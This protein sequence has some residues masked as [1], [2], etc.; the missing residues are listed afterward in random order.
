MIREKYIAVFVTFL[1][2]VALSLSAQAQKLDSILLERLGD[3]L[4]LNY[5][6]DDADSAYNKALAM[7]K[8]SLSQ[9]SLQL[10]NLENKILNTT[11]AQNLLNFVSKPVVVSKQRFSI[12]EFFLF[13]PLPDQSWR[14]VPNQLDS[15][16]KN[17]MITAMYFPADAEKVFY[18]AEDASHARNIYMTEFQDS[19][20]SAPALINEH[21]T[22][23]ANE[24][25]PMLSPDGKSLFFASSGLYGVGAY[26][27]YVSKWNE[28]AKDWGTP[29]NMGFPYSSPADDFMF[30]NTAYGKYSIFASN[31]ECSKD[32]VYLY[33]LEYDSMPVRSSLTA[34]EAKELSLLKPVEDASRMDNASAA[35]N[36]LNESDDI[37]NYM[38]KMGQ[39]RALRDTIDVYSKSIDDRRNQFAASDNADERTKLTAEILKMEATLPV[40]QDSLVKMSA[41]V[42]AIEMDFLFKGVVIDPSKLAKE[43]DKEVV[44][45]ATNYTFVKQTMGAALDIKV[46][47]PEVLFDYSFQILDEAQMAENQTLP[48]GLVYQIQIL[49]QSREATLKQLK[50]LSPVFLSHPSSA[51]YIYR[52][53]LFKTYADVL[54]NLNKVKRLGFRSAFITAFD[55]GKSITVAN[56]R[57]LEK[58]RAERKW[59]V[60]LPLSESMTANEGQGVL[61]A[62]TEKDIAKINKDGSV[63]FVVT[64]FNNKEEA[65]K[66]CELAKAGGF[67]EATSEVI[68]TE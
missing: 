58:K 29:E 39:V 54:S 40:L 4:H 3:S 44:G 28:D 31:R 37:K 25:Y 50:G 17:P 14:P 22:S 30:M 48:Q 36:S 6:F 26:D 53:G 51:K 27:L 59:Q 60:V 68:A 12:D 46:A 64:S 2:S 16:G 18:S 11:N 1:T 56:A 66:F 33:V 15:I 9:D 35:S 57:T 49:S 23:S 24:I 65:D 5:L 45:A 19:L 34:K 43:A 41:Q 32:S 8:D 52:V 42:Q 55:S 10:I 67:K 38:A 62:L 7:Y 61:T 21:L 63:V 13:Y 20:W 47:E